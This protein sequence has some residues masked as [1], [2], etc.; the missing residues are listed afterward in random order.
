MKDPLE[1]LLYGSQF[2]KLLEKKYE[3]IEK[4]YGLYNIDILILL[5]LENAGE[6]NTPKDIMEMKLFTKGHI[7]QALGRL[8]QKGYVKIEHDH[9]DRRYA[10]SYLTEDAGRLLEE[11]KKASR[12]IRRILTAG[13]SPE[14]QSVL[15][16]TAEK[17]EENIRRALEE[18][19]RQGGGG[20]GFEE[21]GIFL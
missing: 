8:Q 5:F 7:S 13:I 6:N 9:R 14:Q 10:H 21:T 20:T 19:K 12:E 16:Q 18:E 11:I 3:T 1:A 4:R 2:R 17:I 15:T